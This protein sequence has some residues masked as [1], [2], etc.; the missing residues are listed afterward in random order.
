MVPHL[1]ED[2]TNGDGARFR[3]NQPTFIVNNK[4][5]IYHTSGSVELEVIIFLCLYVIS[6][7]ILGSPFCN[8]KKCSRRSD[9]R[10]EE[11]MKIE[12]LFNQLFKPHSMG[13]DCVLQIM[14]VFQLFR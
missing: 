4:S 12:S 14:G 10:T 2:N 11:E 8:S 7:V 5:E 1:G 13:L 9:A 6:N 3:S